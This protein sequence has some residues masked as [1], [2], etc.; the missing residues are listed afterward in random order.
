MLLCNR[1]SDISFLAQAIGE[2][3]RVAH[4][5]TCLTHARWENLKWPQ[6]V[7]CSLSFCSINEAIQLIFFTK[8]PM[9]HMRSC[10]LYF[11]RTLNIVAQLNVQPGRCQL[12]VS[13]CFGVF[14]VLLNPGFNDLLELSTGFAVLLVLIPCLQLL[15]LRAASQAFSQLSATTPDLMGRRAK[16]T[17]LLCFFKDRLAS[18]QASNWFYVFQ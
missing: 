5:E 13:N 3:C 10:E 15:A 17:L 7:F 8:N 1:C 12:S 18:Y 6:N 9:N 4:V 16:M 14:F 11:T 2:L